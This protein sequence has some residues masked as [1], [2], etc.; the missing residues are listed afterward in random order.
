MA[1]SSEIKKRIEHL[2]KTIKHHRYLYHVKDTEEISASALD[3]L[4]Y[5]L[6][7]LEE[8]YPELKTPDSPTERIAGEPLPEFKKVTH[9]IPQWSFNDAFT[10]EDL[11]N[12]ETRIKKILFNHFARSIFPEYTCELKIDGLKIVLTYKKGV[13]YTAATRGDGVIGEDATLNVKT[14]ESVPLKLTKPIDVIVEGE[15]WMGKK[16]LARINEER[17]KKNE[18]PFANPRNAA[19]GSIRQ[20]DPKIAASRRLNSFIYDLSFSEHEL[21]KTQ[22][23]ELHMLKA[24]GFKVNTHFSLCANIKEVIAFW[25]EWKKNAKKEDYLLDGIVV[26]VNERKYQEVLGYTGKAP[27]LAI[28]FKFPAEQVTTVVK[29]IVLQVGRTGVLT[30]VAHLN[31]VSVAGSVVSRATLHNE[32]EI[33]RLDVRTGDTVILQKAGDV[34]PDI[35]GVIKE[36]RTGKEKPFIFPKQVPEC[37][38]DGSIER[39]EGQA[40]WRCKHKNSFAQV[41]RKFHYF[42]SKKA[43]NIDGLGPQILNLFLEKGLVHSFDDIFTLKAG[44]VQGLPGFKEKS[45]ANLLSSIE[46]SKKI[47]LSRFLVSLSI[48]HLGEE[49]AEDSAKAFGTLS[50]IINASREEFLRVEGVGPV[51]AGSLYKFF[52]D[53]DNKKLLTRLLKHITVESVLKQKKQNLPLAGKT[54]VLTGTLTSFSRDEAKQKIKKLGGEVNGSVS[55]NTDYV[56][57]GKN[58][59]SKYTDAQKLGVKILSEKEFLKMT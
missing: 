7:S 33:K 46:K 47:S 6:A 56:V 58:P 57:A 38:R 22:Y 24:L 32:D 4:K 42:V 15:I 9:A 37:G 26:K 12:F 5:E 55:K 50:K 14:I 45:V 18:A 1:V 20:L 41:Q 48:D 59:G 3:S 17:K 34:I 19:A 27:R 49:T 13:L 21:P 35:V 39:I 54:F 29:D 53:D 28:A 44:D 43:F 23:E 25:E 40:A 2:R 36:M 8:K 30:P 10:E 31:P 11:Y 51:V 52:H 16:E